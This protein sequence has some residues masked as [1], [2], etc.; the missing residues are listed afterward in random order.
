MNPYQ[1]ESDLYCV[2]ATYNTRDDGFL[3]VLNTANTGGV[4]GEPQNPETNSFFG[5]LCAEQV[6][7]GSL[8]VAPCF[9]QYG[10]P[11]MAGPYWV[12]ALGDDSS[13][14]IVSGGPPNQVRETINGRTFCTTKEG[15]SFL[16]TNGSGLWLF[17]RQRVASAKKISMME[18]KLTEMGI[19][20][21]DLKPVVQGEGCTYPDTLKEAKQNQ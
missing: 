15:S 11:L 10:F 13:W 1:S 21:G 6:D 16:D 14:A 18:A 9:L 20:T 7:G 17:T 2:V 12:L 19:Y 3:Q 5:R 4:D 8:R